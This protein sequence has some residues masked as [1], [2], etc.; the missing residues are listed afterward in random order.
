MA[1]YA[2]GAPMSSKIYITYHVHHETDRQIIEW[3]VTMEKSLTFAIETY[4]HLHEIS[5][6]FLYHLFVSKPIS[7]NNRVL[8]YKYKCVMTLIE[9]GIKMIQNLLFTK[10]CF[11]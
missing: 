8:F 9:L 7:L 11:K 1:A 5:H 4:F 2:N 3:R 6:S 10:Q